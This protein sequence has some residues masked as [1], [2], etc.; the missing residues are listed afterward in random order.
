MYTTSIFKS[1][2]TNNS[3]T[4]QTFIIYD[5]RSTVGIK[6]PTVQSWKLSMQP[7]FESY[8]GTRKTEYSFHPHKSQDGADDK[9]R[10][11]TDIKNKFKF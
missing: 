9:L 10:N 7:I 11:K 6:V 3:N 8:I 2:A 5:G 1:W 4:N